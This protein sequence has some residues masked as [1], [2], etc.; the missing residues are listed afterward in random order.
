MALLTESSIRARARAATTVQKS[1]FT[2]LK[3]HT[4]VQASASQH[5]IFLSHAY[6]DRDIVL[7]VALLIQDYGYKVY[8]DWRD[9]S[10]LD[11]S[12]VSSETAAVLR[13]RMNASR[14]LLYSTTS[15]ASESKWMPW[16]LGFKDGHN[17]RVAILPVV[18]QSA[19]SYHGQEYLG[20]YPYVDEAN[21]A[22]GSKKL[23]VSRSSTCYIDFDSWLNGEVLREH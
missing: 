16:E 9:D 5:D 10:T 6:A 20:I 17:S 18:Q 21:S 1:A 3:E 14:C 2:I 8:I 15:N 19:M 11:R 13:A 7:G 23:W 12:K 22:A 4:R